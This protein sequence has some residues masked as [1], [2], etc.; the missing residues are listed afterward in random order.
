MSIPKRIAGLHTRLNETY[1]RRFQA[2][3]TSTLGLYTTTPLSE[4]GSSLYQQILRFIE[5]LTI[6]PFSIGF[7]EH[8][9]PSISCPVQP[10]EPWHRGKPRGLAHYYGVT[11][12]STNLGHSWGVGL[13]LECFCCSK[14]VGLVFEVWME[15]LYLR[16][17]GCDQCLL[18]SSSDVA[19]VRVIKLLNWESTEQIPCVSYILFRYPGWDLIA[20]RMHDRRRIACRTDV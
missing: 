7:C 20:V 16:I 14:W 18:F 1:V 9:H 2:L 12:K 13:S 11:V 4:P 15:N 6:N 17:C 5:G 19:E 8:F 3:N 10:Q